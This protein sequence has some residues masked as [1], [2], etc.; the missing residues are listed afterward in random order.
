MANENDSNILDEMV[1]MPESAMAEYF[2]KNAHRIIDDA[3][4]L[5]VLGT[6][7]KLGGTVMQQDLWKDLFQSHRKK[8]HKIMKKRERKRWRK[9]PGVVTAYR[10]VNNGIESD[11]AISWTLSKAIAEKFFICSTREVV[12]R[13]FDKKDI[14]AFF[15]RRQEDE[16]LVNIK[17]GAP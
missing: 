1:T 7:W 12:S 15:D 5:N 8:Q 10:A 4:Y 2:S 6:L 17:N 11:A 16:I 9:L 13:R 14:F 3:T